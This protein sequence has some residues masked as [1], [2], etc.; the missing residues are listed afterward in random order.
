M[1]R[2]ALPALLAALVAAGCTGRSSASKK[3]GSDAA[4]A[5]EFSS[6]WPKSDAAALEPEARQRLLEQALVGLK[7]NDWQHAQ[8]VLIALGRD[9]VPALIDMVGSKEPTAASAGPIPSAKVKTLGQLA[10]D[11]LLLIVQNRSSYKGEMPARDQDSWKRWW[12][13]NSS[14]VA[15]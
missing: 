2:I 6:L 15:S 3:E 11:T 9:S 5:Q 14:R 8:D 10:N 12:A 4:Q 13:E 1:I 7:G